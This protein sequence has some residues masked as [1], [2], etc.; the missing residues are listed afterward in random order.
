MAD[1]TVSLWSGAQ[2]IDCAP[3]LV[4]GTRPFTREEGSGNIAIRA[5]SRCLE[6]GHDQSDHSVVNRVHFSACNA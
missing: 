6:C 5:L 1:L 4:W 2:M 3:S